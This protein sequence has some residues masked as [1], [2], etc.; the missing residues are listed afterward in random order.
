[1]AVDLDQL[2]LFRDIVQLRSISRGAELHGVTQSAASQTVQELERVLDVRLLDRSRRP[3]EVTGAGQI[4]HDF[5]RDMLR[6]RNEL[7]AELERVRRTAAPK[8][9]LACIYSI[10]L[11]EMVRLEAAFARRMPEARL[12]VEYLRPERVYE[13]VRDDRADLGVV[14]YPEPAR[15]LELVPWREE[16]MVVAAAPSHAFSRYPRLRASELDGADFISFDADLPIARNIERFLRDHG[17]RVRPVLHFDNIQSLKEALREGK[18]VSVLPEPVLR[19]D[20]AE[21]RLRAI[22][23]F[24]VLLRPLGIL[25]RRRRVMARAVQAFLEVLRA[26]T[27]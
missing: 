27:A 14:S 25:Y 18:A 4:V 10:G 17:A 19:T 7:D 24:P 22:P 6:R 20:V 1:M 8:V 12:E 15:D 5:A 2:A 16:T 13:A 23:L 26:P 9:R 3:L 11:S 21:G